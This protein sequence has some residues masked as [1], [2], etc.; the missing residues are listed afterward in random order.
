MVGVMSDSMSNQV[1]FVALAS[2]CKVASCSL[3][4]LSTETRRHDP[5]GALQGRGVSS[6]M[7]PTNWLVQPKFPAWEFA[8]FLGLWGSQPQLSPQGGPS[9]QSSSPPLLSKCPRLFCNK[10]RRHHSFSKVCSHGTPSVPCW[11]WCL[12]RQA[13]QGT[14]SLS[15]QW[16]PLWPWLQCRWPERIDKQRRQGKP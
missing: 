7:R 13:W 16:S 10:S 15:P 1:L 12:T 11:T 9:P 4:S 14:Q 6:G 5:F 8:G 2:F 3:G